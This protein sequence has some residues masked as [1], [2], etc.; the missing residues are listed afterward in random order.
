MN[1]IKMKKNELVSEVAKLRKQSEEDS[2]AISSLKTQLEDAQA[3]VKEKEKEL[4]ALNK[5]LDS[6]SSDVVE[7]TTEIQNLRKQ[8][9][10][11]RTDLQ[12]KQ[13]DIDCL[14][15]C[16]STLK[17]WKGIAITAVIALF[18]TLCVMCG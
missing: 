5:T 6:Y 2:F 3:K 8:V 17:V 15:D 1:P 12:A 13:K 11:L 4:D 18:I 10:E 7:K 14:S 9:S 16:L